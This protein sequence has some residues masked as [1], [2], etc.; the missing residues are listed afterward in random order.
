MN[1]TEFTTKLNLARNQID[2][3]E[4]VNAQVISVDEDGGYTLVHGIALDETV[5]GW[6]IVIQGTRMGIRRKERRWLRRWYR[7]FG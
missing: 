6:L 3:K 5:D 2:L 1:L 7:V 4:A